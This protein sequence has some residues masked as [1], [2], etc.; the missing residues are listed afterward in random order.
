[1]IKKIK[2]FIFPCKDNDYR[3]TLLDGNFLLYIALV[4]VLLK[5]VGLFYFTLLPKTPYFA[6][7]TRGVLV[8]MTNNERMAAGLKPLNENQ[9]LIK[10]AELKAKDMLQKNY[11]SHWSPDGTSPWYWFGV[12]GYNYRYAGENLAMGFLNAKDV[13]RA[14]IASPDHKSNIL[15]PNYSDIGIA[16][17][18][19]DFFGQK[20]FLIV[21]VFGSQDVAETV[22]S[23]PAPVEEFATLEPI[24]LEDLPELVEAPAIINPAVN[25]DFVV[26][27]E[28]DQ[29]VS[30]VLGVGSIISSGGE[31]ETEGVRYSIFKFLIMEY[32]NLVGQATLLV[33]TFLGFVMVMNIFVRF[34]I[35]HPDLIFKGLAFFFLFLVFEHF[36]QMTLIRMVMGDPWI[37]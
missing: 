1:M 15:G 14:W 4:L 10:A 35:Q 21:Q 37:G 12:V 3:P 6:D 11:F 2:L 36:D 26:D 29:E 23:V 30:S 34:N 32:D 19:G 31:S 24:V 33:I 8:Q 9:K 16:V 5:L 13:H 17:V 20:T 22:V 28:L 27:E 18:E 7:I 25:D